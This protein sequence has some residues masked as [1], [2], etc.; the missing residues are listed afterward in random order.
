MINFYS[1]WVK[2]R[3]IWNS[4][5]EEISWWPQKLRDPWTSNLLIQDIKN[6]P[7][8]IKYFRVHDINTAHVIKGQYL[9]VHTNRYG[10]Q[11]C[12]G[13]A[14]MNI[15]IVDAINR[16]AVDLTV[17]FV[18]DTLVD[19]DFAQFQQDVIRRL[20]MMNLQRPGAVNIIMGTN[21]KT[22][23]DHNELGIKWLFYPW[24][25][26]LLQNSWRRDLR[27]QLPDIIDIATK[28][29]AY[30]SLG[31]KNFDHRVKLVRRLE[32]LGLCDRGIIT[33][34]RRTQPDLT[35]SDKVSGTDFAQ[36]LNANPAMDQERYIDSA[37]GITGSA[38]PLLGS[39]G[40]YARAAW[41]V[42]QETTNTVQQGAFLTEKTFRSMIMGVPF[43]VNGDRGYLTTLR[44][45]GYQ[46]F[47]EFINEDYDNIDDP[48]QRVL[49]VADEIQKMCAWSTDHKRSIWPKLRDILEHN[50]QLCANTEHLRNVHD[51]LCSS[52]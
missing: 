42:V 44:N 29:L 20:R 15:P 24:Y 17:M 37:D 10:M 11:D 34:S 25:A 30:M 33:M 51:L 7:G 12:Q 49:A 9:I 26:G 14:C 40:F 50:Q 6:W 38:K 39:R 4:C 32:Q 46:T 19:L 1:H 48:D 8:S 45:L 16:G 13:L 2:D 23:S 41:D 52:K 36:W 22:M 5:H 3:S 43:I 47:G 28:P 21:F 27:G 31:G 18:H 35:L